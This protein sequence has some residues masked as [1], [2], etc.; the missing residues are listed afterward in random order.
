MVV[1]TSYG[2]IYDEPL[3]TN[4]GV[5][6][7]ESIAAR[8]MRRIRTIVVDVTRVEEATTSGFARL[9][10]AR[11]SLRDDG[12]DIVLVGLQGRALGLFEIY[13]LGGI[14]PLQ[15]SVCEDPIKGGE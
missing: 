2:V 13:R 8:Q 1:T 15:A 6:H 5:E 12:R 7:I 10:Q 4:E 9:V 3:L 11:R 14:L